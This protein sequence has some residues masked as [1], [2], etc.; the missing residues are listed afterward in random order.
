MRVRRT[1]LRFGGVENPKNA[2]PSKPMYACTW[3]PIFTSYPKFAPRFNVLLVSERGRHF[4]VA[5]ASLTS[6]RRSGWD[7]AAQGCGYYIF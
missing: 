1:L 3:P 2:P 5:S 4:H 7:I 6:E